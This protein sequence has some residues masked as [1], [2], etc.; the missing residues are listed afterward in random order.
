MLS[1]APAAWASPDGRLGQLHAEWSWMLDEERPVGWPAV[2]VPCLVIAFEHD[3]YL[4]AASRGA[5]GRAGHAHGRFA[6]VAGVTHSGHLA[7]ADQVNRLLI[8]FLD[9]Q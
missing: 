6:E 1:Q 9:A 3:L 8:N 5:R 4:P 7:H 2:E